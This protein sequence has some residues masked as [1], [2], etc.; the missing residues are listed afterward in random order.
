MNT[1]NLSKK[2]IIENYLLLEISKGNLKAGD[3]IPSEIELVKKFGF[4]RQT[5]HNCLKDLAIKGVIERTPG[6]GSFVS[7]K[8][9]DRNITI[10]KSFTDDMHSIG[11]VPGASLIEYRI[12]T[13]KEC[14][15]K[16]VLKV[17]DD[18]LV[19]YT[20]RIRTGNGIPIALQYSYTPKRVFPD[21]L[22]L[23]ALND[24]FDNYIAKEG[25]EVKGFTTRIKAVEASEEQMSMLG[26]SEKVLLRTISTRYVDENTPIQTTVTYYRSDLYEYSFS[27]F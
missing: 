6:K 9:V 25:I 12:I 2:Q 21:G 10:K 13:G 1:K 17:E 11:M 24:S 16:D 20:V 27:S 15:V 26:I 18:E 19:Y 4:G 22:D 3:R 8:P 23:N 7:R 5:I 14:T